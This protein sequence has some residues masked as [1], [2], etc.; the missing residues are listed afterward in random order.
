[1]SKNR[2][3]GIKKWRSASEAFIKSLP[4]SLLIIRPAARKNIQSVAAEYHF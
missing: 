2:A 3:K 1:M 4:F